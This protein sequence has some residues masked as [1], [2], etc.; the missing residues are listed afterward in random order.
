MKF[1][2]VLKRAALRARRS[3]NSIMSLV[4]CSVAASSRR[5]SSSVDPSIARPLPLLRRACAGPLEEVSRN[6]QDAA[7]AI[8][9]QITKTAAA[10]SGVQIASS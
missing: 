4:P 9:Y 2:E 6:A 3:R 8:G 7:G 5:R 10:R 1:L